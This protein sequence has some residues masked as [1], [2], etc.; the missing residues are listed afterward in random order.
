[1]PSFGM[2]EV[3]VML[4]G[5][6]IYAIPIAVAVWIIIILNRIHSGQKIIQNRLDEI[7]RTVRQGRDR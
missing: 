6:S 3:I 4:A 1:M 2:T 5:L 7:E